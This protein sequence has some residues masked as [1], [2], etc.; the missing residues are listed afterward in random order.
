MK[1][2][3]VRLIPYLLLFALMFVLN[4]LFLPALTIQSPGFRLLIGV[5]FIGVLFIELVIDIDIS[6]RKKVNRAKYTLIS[7]PIVFVLLVFAIQFFNG[8]IFRS[9]DY[10]N[11]IE[12][13]EKD[14]GSDFYAMNTDQIPMMDRDTAER[15]GDRRI[16]SM[17]DL[18]SQ[19]VPANAYT[20]IN[21][22]NDP[23][24]VTPLEYSGFMQWLN[25]RKEGIPNYLKV[26]MV[27][28]EVTVE[29][30]A[31]NI[32]YSHSER[33]A[34]NVKRHLRRHYPT[35]IFRS[36]SLKLMMKAIHIMLRQHIK[37]SSFSLTKSQVV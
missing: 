21:I 3:F 36:P 12:V 25:N 26:D 10:A 5:F 17:S 7:L 16:G 28:G 31:E 19:F 23:Y 14:F 33:F 1:K 9:K 32:K 13:V 30:L 34:R 8:P 22:G 35:T 18:V 2:H 6:G 11:L 15:L 20:Q 37:I 4:Y 27:S 24:R 29:D